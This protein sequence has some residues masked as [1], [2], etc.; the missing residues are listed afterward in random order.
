M[1]KKRK[2]AFRFMHT[3]EEV[4]AWIKEVSGKPDLKDDAILIQSTGSKGTRITLLD[5]SC[6]QPSFQ[7]QKSFGEICKA[8]IEAGKT[9]FEHKHP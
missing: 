6:C 9:A 1:K 7:L 3:T 4:K 8:D 2:F 5:K